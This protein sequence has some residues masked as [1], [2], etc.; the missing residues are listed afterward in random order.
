MNTL[1]QC[2]KYLSILKKSVKEKLTFSDVGEE[3]TVLYLLGSLGWSNQIDM[4]KINK[5]K[6][7]HLITYVHK[8]NPH[9]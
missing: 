1:Y 2:I 3:E 8:G 6:W 9:T 5:R 4:R 7:P